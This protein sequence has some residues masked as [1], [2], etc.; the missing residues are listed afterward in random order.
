MQRRNYDSRPA[1]DESP[2]VHAR[3]I[4]GV[5]IDLVEVKRFRMLKEKELSPFLRKV[6]TRRELD[7]CFA[8]KDPAPHLAGTFAVKEAVVKAY[9]EGI[10]VFDVEVVRTKAGQPTVSGRGKKICSVFVSISHTAT[11][12]S[13]IAIRV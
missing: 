2:K 10:S 4:R 8:F 12:A 5:G 11:M 1:Y 13:S 3:L 9:G 7:Y 6:F